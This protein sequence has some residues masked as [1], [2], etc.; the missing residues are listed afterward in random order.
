MSKPLHQPTEK[1][2][3]EIIALRSYGVPIK[4]VAAYIG[5]D[6][7][8][9]YKYYREE[10]ENSATKANANVGKFLYQ[11]ASG[12]A[13]TTGATYS[14]CVRAAMFW[15]KTRMGWKETNVQEHTGA[16]GGVIQVNTTAMSAEEAYNLLINGGTIKT[17]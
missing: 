8:T 16:N 3:A 6:D 11:A 5:I 2:R 14:D 17:D 9:L 4:E 13:L 7:K 10:L 12:Q 15:A 1:T